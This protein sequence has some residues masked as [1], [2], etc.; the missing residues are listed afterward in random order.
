MN[1]GWTVESIPRAPGPPTCVSDRWD[2]GGWM[3]GG[4][5]T[6]EPEEM[7]QEP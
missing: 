3:P 1:H 6:T 7:G 5:N 2:R 4:S